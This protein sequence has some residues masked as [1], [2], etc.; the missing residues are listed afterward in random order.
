M[1]LSVEN[2]ACAADPNQQLLEG[3]ALALDLWFTTCLRTFL[4]WKF[5]LTTAIFVSGLPFFAVAV[6]SLFS[7]IIP[8]SQQ[9]VGQVTIDG[10]PV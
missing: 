2:A 5:I 10:R 3:I 4:E 1:R 9:G 7:K 8:D 6:P